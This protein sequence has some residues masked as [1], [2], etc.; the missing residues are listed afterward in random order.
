MPLRPRNYRSQIDWPNW[1]LA[2]RANW[3]SKPH[4][5]EWSNSSG[6]TFRRGGY[7]ALA[8]FARTPPQAVP[9]PSRH[10][11]PFEQTLERVADPDLFADPVIFCNEAHRFLVG[12]MLRRRKQSAGAILLETVAR[13]TAPAACA[14]ALSLAA[15]DPDALLLLLP[16]DHD[17]ADRAGF[18]AAVELAAQAAAT[19]WLVTFGI[20][21][22]RPETGYGYIRY[23]GPLKGLPGCRQVGQFVEKPDQ[24]TAERYLAA[25]N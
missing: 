17:I 13:N 16:S 5:M 25:G 20:T 19:G 11:S 23:A 3:V 4:G 2:R 22:S 1:P 8:S 24:T 15:G 6:D 18:L 7:A 14:A 10:P 21:P 9:G 12:E